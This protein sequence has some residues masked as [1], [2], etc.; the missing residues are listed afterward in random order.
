M[1]HLY[2]DKQRDLD[3]LVLTF[4]GP[5][6]TM[7]AEILIGEL[8]IS[9]ANCY[10][11]PFVE[12]SHYSPIYWVNLE[13]STRSLMGTLITRA[14]LR[15]I[16]AIVPVQ[17]SPKMEFAVPATIDPAVRSLVV[18]FAVPNAILILEHKEEKEKDPLTYYPGVVEYETWIKSWN[19]F[20]TPNDVLRFIAWANIK[21]Q[22]NMA[23]AKSH[24]P[25]RLYFEP[26]RR[27]H[28]MVQVIHLRGKQI[29]D[30]DRLPQLWLAMMASCKD[31]YGLSLTA[32]ALSHHALLMYDSAAS[33]CYIGCP[34][35]PSHREYFVPPG[36]ESINYNPISDRLRFPQML[37]APMFTSFVYLLLMSRFRMWS[38][39]SYVT[40]D[41]M[42]GLLNTSAVWLFSRFREQ[43][44]D[45][46][47]PFI[48]PVNI[49][50]K[51]RSE[52]FRTM[53]HDV[54][55]HAQILVSLRKIEDLLYNGNRREMEDPTISMCIRQA[56]A[57]DI[58][59]ES[60]ELRNK[61]I[62]K[63]KKYYALREF[64]QM[65]HYECQIQLAALQHYN[66]D[67]VILRAL[68][69]PVV[70]AD[71]RTDAYTKKCS[72]GDLNPARATSSSRWTLHLDSNKDKLKDDPI[73]YHEILNCGQLEAESM[74][75][76]LGQMTALCQYF[77]VT[78][79]TYNTIIVC[80][81]SIWYRM[82]TSWSISYV[83]ANTDRLALI[84]TSS[85]TK[86]SV[87]PC[88]LQLL[89]S[90]FSTHR[91]EAMQLLRVMCGWP[92]LW[93]EEDLRHLLMV[94]QTIRDEFG[95]INKIMDS[96][97][98]DLHARI[99]HTLLLC[100]GLEDDKY[101]CKFDE[102]IVNGSTLHRS[103][104]DDDKNK[105][106]TQSF[107]PAS[108]R[109]ARF[110][111]TF[112]PD[113][114]DKEANDIMGRY[115][116]NSI[117][118]LNL[119]LDYGGGLG[120]VPKD[121]PVHGNDTIYSKSVIEMQCLASKPGA[122]ILPPMEP[123][124]HGDTSLINICGLLQRLE[125]QNFRHYG[126]TEAK[127]KNW[128][129]EANVTSQ[130]L[131]DRLYPLS[132]SFSSPLPSTQV[133]YSDSHFVA[134][135][136]SIVPDSREVTDPYMLFVQRWSEMIED[137]SRSR[138]LSVK[139]DM[140]R[141]FIKYNTIASTAKPSQKPPPPVND[142]SPPSPVYH[143]VSPQYS[144]VHA[145]V[146]ASASPQFSPPSPQYDLPVT[147]VVGG[148]R[149]IDG[150]P[151][152]GD[153]RSAPVDS[154]DDDDDNNTKESAL[155]KLIHAK[156]GPSPRAPPPRKAMRTVSPD[157]SSVP[158]PPITIIVSAARADDDDNN[159][160]NLFKS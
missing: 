43:K 100:G 76:G 62:T 137:S 126:I 56:R 143:A 102:D 112:Y 21:S 9:D 96:T 8:I 40:T 118:T 33:S 57:F 91:I 148:G 133:I 23:M 42:D 12:S 13:E 138:Y 117:E 72:T 58:I 113:K 44:F 38:S 88:V 18:E 142:D 89:M 86:F 64:R 83:L 116:T 85:C 68:K 51:E 90:K 48:E 140:A 156:L 157:R 36:I 53:E 46:E 52:V 135:V 114:S 39:S 59:Y 109:W 49:D 29:S 47:Q 154:D 35:W 19:R 7:F 150:P 77:S 5:R 11:T 111:L 27:L 60:S 125:R 124:V 105:Y 139:D 67:S 3:R 120:L 158:S 2:D 132:M 159:L 145:P 160:F 93:K 31:R 73:V 65:T 84:T 24:E 54:R 15:S 6:H 152:S 107:T 70:A 95:G 131:S 129:I 82:Q 98:D 16:P 4:N 147:V 79:Q 153:K 110:L 1:R 146:A 63:Q 80:R 50:F 26:L 121:V 134:C 144:P 119:I 94:A 55:I 106:I 123:F 141:L 25:I 127:V 37:S 130:V 34:E 101:R 87:V 17:K 74:V 28:S 149:R 115:Y 69:K 22:Y 78:T 81:R 61:Y 136:E 10:T 122:L 103:E 30:R 71:A 75:L 128:C 99:I 108:K 151:V 155:D 41:K 92:R 104:I 66:V 97:V 14:T 20:S 32:P 45:P